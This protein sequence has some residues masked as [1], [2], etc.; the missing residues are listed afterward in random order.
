MRHL[1]SQ[2]TL[3]QLVCVIVWRDCY[4]VSEWRTNAGNGSSVVK[5]AGEQLRRDFASSI[6]RS[7]HS[8]LS[9][10]NFVLPPLEDWRSAINQHV[11]CRVPANCGVWLRVSSAR[12]TFLLRRR[13]IADNRS[14]FSTRPSL[15]SFKTYEC[16]KILAPSVLINRRRCHLRFERFQQGRRRAFNEHLTVKLISHNPDLII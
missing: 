2:T 15:Y 12:Q 5:D 10:F 8:K 9:A 1:K 6:S 13:A 16:A 3:E 11:L 7:V 4:H 14:W